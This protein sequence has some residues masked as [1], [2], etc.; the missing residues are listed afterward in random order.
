MT[1][2]I[3]EKNN[4]L[5]VHAVCDTLERAYHWI[6]VKAPEYVSKGYFI[7]KSLTANS[8][9]IATKGKPC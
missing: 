6:N 1:Y 3:V 7:D 2:Y 8:F 4:H 9:A 5:A